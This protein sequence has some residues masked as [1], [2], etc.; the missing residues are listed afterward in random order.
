LRN[1]KCLDVHGGKDEEAR[2]VIVWNKHNGANQ[3]WKI[4]YLDDNKEV[5]QNGIDKE[6]GFHRNRPFYLVSRMPFKRVAEAHPNN[7]VYLRRYVKNKA[8]QRWMFNGE[9]KCIHSDWRK[10][11]VMERPSKGNSNNLIITATITSRQW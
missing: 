10:N 1:K 8:Q 4:D 11:Y 9:D 2:K 3:R 6:F 7:H 5:E